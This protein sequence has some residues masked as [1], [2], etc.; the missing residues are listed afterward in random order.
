MTIWQ[1]SLETSKFNFTAYADSKGA[2]KA[3]LIAT[4]AIHGTQYELPRD[5]YRE[6][7]QGDGDVVYTRCASGHGYRDGER[8]LGRDN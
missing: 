4:L 1:A 5:W 7:L 6:Y 3:V 8:I 2:A